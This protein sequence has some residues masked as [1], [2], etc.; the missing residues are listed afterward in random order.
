MANHCKLH[1]VGNTCMAHF[2][3]SLLHFTEEEAEA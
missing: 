2:A 3:E 1:P